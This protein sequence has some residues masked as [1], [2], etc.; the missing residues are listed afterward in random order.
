MPVAYTLQSLDGLSEEVAALYAKDEKEDK[1]VLSV[2]GLPTPEDTKGLKSALQKERTN[3]TTLEAKVK[4]WEKLGETPEAVT[5]KIEGLEKAKGDPTEAEKLLEQA[6]ANHKVEIENVRKTLTEERDAALESE[7]KAV[8]VSGFT[9]ALAKAGFTDTGIDMI[10]TVHSNRIKMVD[11]DGTRVP[12]IM[13]ADGTAPLVGS[14]EGSRATFDDLAK[15]LVEKYPDLV[16]SDR[17]GGG[18][19]P[20]GAGGTGDGK[21]MVR[22]DW[23]KLNPVQQGK[24]LADGF[25]LVDS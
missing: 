3:V 13:T 22:S 14:G 25:K 24:V 9:T 11:R 10:P 16:K 15:E 17:K 23:D 19:T 1:F 6:R 21:T 5:E 18:G 12:E 7:R 4:T 20:P 8:V 2:E